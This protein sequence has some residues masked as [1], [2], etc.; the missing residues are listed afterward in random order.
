MLNF[1]RKPIRFKRFI[2]NPL[3]Y[4]LLKVDEKATP[5]QIKKNYYKEC[6]L[7]HPDRNEGAVNQFLEINKAFQ[8][9]CYKKQIYDNLH[10]MQYQEFLSLW[11]LHFHKN[12]SKIEKMK[13]Y[14]K[15]GGIMGY[16]YSKLIS[17]HN[18]VILYD[19]K[20]IEK[21]I[22]FNQLKH[23]YFIQDVSASMRCFDID[24]NYNSIP[25]TFNSTAYQDGKAVDYYDIDHKYDYIADQSRYI[26]KSI[27]NIKSICEDSDALTSFM[28]FAKSNEILWQYQP[29]NVILPKIDRMLKILP[30]IRDDE[31]TH[32]YDTLKIAIHTVEKNKLTLTTFV[33]ITDGTDFKS[34]TPLSEIVNIV[35]EINII[36]LTINVHCQDLQTICNAAKSGKL[37]QIGNHVNTFE[38]AFTKTK[39]IILH[40]PKNLS[41]DIKRVFDL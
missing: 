26:Y 33:L 41:I 3:L 22:Y 9:L 7:Y 4:E 30:K 27:K 8:I 13:K 14:A 29:V 12:K 40:Q 38:T 34:Y 28:I 32:I 5:L 35:K 16:F 15:V 25:K 31:F 23:L 18:Q 20:E 2:T 10:P 11:T 24:A 36:I 21:S 1:I 6:M 39:D 37:L 19:Q 17:Y